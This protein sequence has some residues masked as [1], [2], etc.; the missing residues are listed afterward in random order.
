MAGASGAIGTFALQLAARRGWAVA[1]SA[2][3]ANHDHLRSLGADLTVD[4]RDPSWQEKVREWRPDGVDGALAV[5]PETTGSSALVVRPGAT[6]VT[7]SGDQSA[8]PGVRVT[9]LAYHVDVREELVSLMQDIVAG[10]ISLVIEK[11]YPF[12]DA[13]SALA[14]TQTRHARGKVVVTLEG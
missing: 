13:L 9:G 1:G 11:V 4:Y 12:A 5:Q 6:V 8:P 2:S 14:K 7:V 3:P 10:D